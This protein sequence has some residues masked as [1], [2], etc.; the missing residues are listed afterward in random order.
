MSLLNF[1]RPSRKK[2]ARI[3]PFVR[4]TENMPDYEFETRERVQFISNEGRRLAGEVRGRTSLKTFL[5]TGFDGERVYD[6]LDTE[7]VSHNRVRAS[8]ITAQE[9]ESSPINQPDLRV[10]S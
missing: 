6:I 9:S 1:F 8:S 5:T 10:V 2:V 3:K 7:G 4:S